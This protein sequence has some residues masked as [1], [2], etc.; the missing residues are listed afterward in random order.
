MSQ[1]KVTIGRREY[2]VA[3]APG[4]EDHVAS[5]GAMIHEKL[6]QLGADLPVSESQNLLFGALFVAD[7]LHEAR[8]SA[9]DRQQ[10]HDRQLSELNETVRSTSV[11]AGQRD[12][13]QLKVNDLE[14]ELDGLQSAQQRHNAEVDDMRAELVQRREEAESAIGERE[15]IASQLAEITRERDSL[16]NKIES[17]N[18]LLEIANDKM[19]ETNAKLDEALNSASHSS[20]NA[21]LADDP[22]LAPA[23]ER[24]ADLLEE[25]ADKLEKH[26]SNT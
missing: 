17:K 12:Q 13:L 25:C 10:E 4:E 7:E 24:F 2:S 11:A 19:R 8:K 23:L 5:L 18:E 14:S 16:L 20:E 15:L 26:D 21:D 9:A 3:C 6:S 22:D 1:V